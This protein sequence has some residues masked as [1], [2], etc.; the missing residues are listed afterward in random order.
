MDIETAQP[1]APLSDAES[2]ARLYRSGDRAR[3]RP[4]GT[5]ECLGRVDTQEK[6]R[7]RLIEPG[8]IEAALLHL[9]GVRQV[10]V[11]VRED[12]PGHK[13]LVAYIAGSEAGT[14]D[15]E[16]IGVALSARL[17][18]HLVPSMVVAVDQL[19]LTPS[20]KLDREALGRRPAPARRQPLEKLLPRDNTETYVKQVWEDVL[21]RRDLD[22]RDNF[23][24]VGGHSLRAAVIASRVSA[25]YAQRVSVAAIIQY[26]TIEQFAAYLRQDVGFVPRGTIVPIQTRGSQVPLFCVHPAAGLASVF[27]ELAQHL[28]PD[29]PVYALQS[30]GYECA[31]APRL[32]IEQMAASYVHDLRGVQPHG[33]YHLC[34]WSM[35][36]LVAYEMARHLRAA[37]EAVDLLAILDQ[38][39]RLP[40]I[41]WRAVG[42]SPKEPSA[43]QHRRIHRL[44]MRAKVSG[45]VPADLTVAHFARF[46]EITANNI[47]AARAY[48]PEP[49]DGP[50]TLFTI[51][52]DAHDPT[53]GWGR[54]SC[55]PVAV[56]PITGEH[57]RLVFGEHA[58]G[59]AAALRE[60][61]AAA[62]HTSDSHAATR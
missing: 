22:V 39:A 50:I 26:P 55:R 24:A 7:G 28:G 14:L 44:L 8:E 35:G 17:P 59:L 58:I 56:R 16:A 5:L 10:A 47:R 46:R 43:A 11:I 32:S 1:P 4:D 29:Q 27:V 25:A 61:I 19:P 33:P 31:V 52:H 38:D 48:R 21:G 20:G 23:F 62:P 49:Y 2:G 60:A 36:G 12:E 54:L 37:G 41:A 15:V 57:D 30:T 3:W 6:I 51:R 18:S 34:G 40:S 45:L 13:Q 9:D 53:R 42:V